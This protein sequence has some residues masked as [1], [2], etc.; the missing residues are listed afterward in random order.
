[1]NRFLQVLIYNIGKIRFDLSLPIPQVMLFDETFFDEGHIVNFNSGIC[2]QRIFLHF[3][4]NQLFRCDVTQ[5]LS[6]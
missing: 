3:Q 6:Y 2:I 5:F 1:M 4:W